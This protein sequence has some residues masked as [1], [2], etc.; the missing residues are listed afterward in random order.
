MAHIYGWQMDPRFEVAAD[1]T[2]ADIDAH[3]KKFSDFVAAKNFSVGTG[4]VDLS[5][6]C[7]AMNQYQ[8]SSCTGNATCESLEI[9][10][11]IATGG[12]TPLSRLFTYAMART[13]EGTLN[14]D[15]GSH[16]RTCFDTLSRFG[17]C[18]E[19][20]WPYDMGQVNVS[21]SLLAQEQA[22]GHKIKAYYRITTDGDQRLTDI[23]T[24]LYNQHPV[25]IGTLV[26]TD[27]ENA[28]P[29]TQPL[30][31]P[32]MNTVKGGHALVIVG[33]VGGWYK[34]KNS[35]GTGWGD[36][37]FCLFTPDYLTWVGTDDLWVPTLAPAFTS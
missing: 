5:S 8:L 21:P 25:V 27:F 13:V 2:T 28:G 22:V 6:Y 14:V 15:G 12:A 20:L 30:G 1:G 37:G 24:A 19:A 9:L 10:E 23:Q 29:A 32:D 18:T 34:I 11:N 31:P 4:D 33:Y 17:V 26:G 35:W 7:V 16:V 36:H 3:D